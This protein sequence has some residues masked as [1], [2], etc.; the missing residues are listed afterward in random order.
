MTTQRASL[1]TSVTNYITSVIRD[2]LVKSRKEK[3]TT[4]DKIDR[5]CYKPVACAS[6]IRGCDVDRI[7][8][9]CL[10]GRRL[11]DRLGQ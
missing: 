5:I 3:L 2:S 6:D 10:N 8:R 9:V 11:G 4:S 1:R 7:L